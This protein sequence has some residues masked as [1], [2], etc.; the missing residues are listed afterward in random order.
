MALDR[1]GGILKDQ[2]LSLAELIASGRELRT[3]I[4]QETYG[5]T[6]TPQENLS[7]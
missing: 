5:I 7:R 1:I 4:L 2:G 3:D 6:E